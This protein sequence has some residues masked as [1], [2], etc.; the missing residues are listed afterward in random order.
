MLSL[1]TCYIQTSR[2]SYNIAFAH[3][4]TKQRYHKNLHCRHHWLHLLSNFV[5]SRPGEITNHWLCVVIAYCGAATSQ[6][7]EWLSQRLAQWAITCQRRY[8]LLCCCWMH[9]LT[10]NTFA[11]TTYESHLLHSPSRRQYTLTRQ[12]REN[13]YKKHDVYL[14]SRSCNILTTYTQRCFKA[15]ES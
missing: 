4:T 6:T 8:Y 13:H 5:I 11:V 3:E 14:I 10:T 1:Y 9:N 15:S 7:T 2:L 12:S